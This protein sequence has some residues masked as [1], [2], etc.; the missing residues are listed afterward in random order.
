M[1]LSSLLRSCFIKLTLWCSNACKIH[2][3]SQQQYERYDFVDIWPV[4]TCRDN[5]TMLGHSMWNQTTLPTWPTWILLIFCL[6]NVAIKKKI[7]NILS[8][9]HERFQN[10]DHLNYDP[11]SLDNKHYNLWHFET[12]LIEAV[13]IV[14][15]WNFE[16]GLIF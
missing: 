3:T 16:W 6:V 8:S 4:F 15:I 10:Y 9:Y 11:F 2:R 14:N 1:S 13:L 12:V 7:L 5:L